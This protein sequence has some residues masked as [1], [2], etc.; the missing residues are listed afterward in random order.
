MN[1]IP[2]EVKKKIWEK[3]RYE[4]DEY[5]EA[6][7]E[8][9][10]FGAEWAIREF[11]GMKWVKASDRLPQGDNLELVW[12]FED[13]SG[14]HMGY[15]ADWGFLFEG[16]RRTK[17]P[18]TDYKIEWLD[19]S[20]DT[21]SKEEV[22]EIDEILDEWRKS[23]SSYLPFSQYLKV[24]K[25]KIIKERKLKLEQSNTG[26]ATSAPFTVSKEEGLNKQAMIDYLTKQFGTRYAHAYPSVVDK[27]IE[28]G[29]NSS[30]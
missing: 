26:E 3:S 1:T 11:S 15:E 2:E 13:K 8:A 7:Y 5:N 6:E 28:I 30:K 18:I 12:R 29:S 24:K 25:Y 19:E 23:E 14:V 10:G 27:L 17:V 4:Y 20:G 16:N 22:Y 21:V 9:F